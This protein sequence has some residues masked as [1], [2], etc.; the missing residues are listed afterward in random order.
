MI[1]ISFGYPSRPTG[2]PVL[3]DAIRRVHFKNVLMFAAASNNGGNRG[4][5]FPARQD[6]VICIHATD[7]YGNPSSFNSSPMKDHDNFST[8]GE[9][10][11]SAWPVRLGKPTSHGVCK[12]RK[13]G[14][15]FATPIAA[16]IAAF[17]LQFRAARTERRRK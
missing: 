13:F 9:D 8:L 15:S 17:L 11:E 6:E 16:G 2:H 12:T 3:E 10:V 7:G 14:T 1:T 4:R 5:A